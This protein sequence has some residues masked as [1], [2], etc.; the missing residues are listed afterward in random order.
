MKRKA[1]GQAFS[2]RENGKRRDELC[3]HENQQLPQY[4]QSQEMHSQQAKRW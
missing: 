3:A 1:T 2:S 4:M